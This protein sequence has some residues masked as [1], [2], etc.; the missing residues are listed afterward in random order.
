MAQ[1]ERVEA[2]L[3]QQSEGTRDKLSR[4]VRSDRQLTRGQGSYLIRGDP[5][6]TS[7]M[8]P[9]VSPADPVVLEAV[10]NNPQPTL[11]AAATS[12]SS[13]P[14]RGPQRPPSES[15][16][17]SRG[18][19]RRGHEHF[20]EVEE[21]HVGGVDDD[22]DDSH[23]F[24]AAMQHTS[25]YVKRLTHTEERFLMT[26]PLPPPHLATRRKSLTDPSR[27][28]PPEADTPLMTYDEFVTSRQTVLAADA[29]KPD[30]DHS[31]APQPKEADTLWCDERG[32]S[33]VT[34]PPY[35]EPAHAEA[36]ASAAGSVPAVADGLLKVPG[37]LPAAS[38][39]PRD[40]A[41]SGSSSDSGGRGRHR[42][43][44]DDE[45][46]AVPWSAKALQSTF[47]QRQF[48]APRSAALR[49]PGGMTRRQRPEHSGP[50]SLT[51]VP[52]TP[53]GMPSASK[54]WVTPPLSRDHQ[55]SQHHRMHLL[56]STL[57]DG[58]RVDET[59]YTLSQQRQRALNL[60][61]CPAAMRQAGS[62]NVSA[63]LSNREQHADRMRRV[64]GGVDSEVSE[65]CSP[66]VPGPFKRNVT[67]PPTRRPKL[68]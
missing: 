44:Q 24:E 7:S 29:V 20:E 15:S 25:T 45:V 40:D 16:A 3:Q 26:P 58:V 55:P 63:A 18:R 39:Q 65:A 42:M 17:Q 6:Y 8:L 67:N 60:R 5:R 49:S 28:R 47:H 51:S 48:A 27:R 36:A 30:T 37:R 68:R 34:V 56:H 21:Q 59:A 13:A 52:E 10:L 35:M 33:G 62:S 1:A 46:A 4:R 2:P 19:V 11:A 9:P 61:S 38:T 54:H 22:D 31:S 66:I 57:H 50:S 14:A 43:C 53:L 23:A 41:L 32:D 12:T 64:V